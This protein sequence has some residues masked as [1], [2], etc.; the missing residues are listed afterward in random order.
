MMGEAMTLQ[1]IFRFKDEGFDKN[2]R[3]VGQFQAMGLIPTFI[4]KFESRGITIPR[5]LFTTNAGA[6]VSG[7]PAVVKATTAKPSAP[8]GSVAQPAVKKA[9]GGETR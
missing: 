7:K 8:V 5:N 1:E 6:T 2:R 9:S 3:V 4:E